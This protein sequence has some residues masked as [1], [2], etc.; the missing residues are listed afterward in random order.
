MH[1]S[2]DGNSIAHDAKHN[3]ILPIDRDTGIFADVGPK[4]ISLRIFAKRSHFTPEFL[5]KTEC[6]NRIVASNE[7]TDL[8]QISLDVLR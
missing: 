5:H 6:A 2:F 7:I 3:Q 1:H 8:L 4:L